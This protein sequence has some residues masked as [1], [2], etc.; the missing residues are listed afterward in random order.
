MKYQADETIIRITYELFKRVGGVED[1]PEKI[2]V[3]S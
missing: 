3:N 1:P 2:S